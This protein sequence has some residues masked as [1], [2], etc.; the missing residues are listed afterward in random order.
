MTGPCSTGEEWGTTQRAGRL[1][2]PS[3]SFTRASRR[4]KHVSNGARAMAPGSSGIE[5]DGA[6]GEGLGGGMRGGV[7]W[8]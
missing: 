4:S 6:T 5:A 2:H 1:Y 3:I 8:W 7:R